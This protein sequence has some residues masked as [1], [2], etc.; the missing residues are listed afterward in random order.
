MRQ[1]KV[2]VIGCGGIAERAHIPNLLAEPQVRLE[3]LSDIDESKLVAIQ[4]KFNLPKDKSFTDYTKV[5]RL[6][7][8]DAVVIA[9][10]THTHGEIVLKAI[11]AE[12]HVFVE[13]PLSVTVA[14]AEAIV[15]SA[16]RAD[17]KVMVGYQHRFVSVHK[18]AKRY[19]RTGKIGVP[20]FGEVHSESLIVKPEEG[21]LLDYGV[22]LIDLLCWYLDDSKVKE[23]AALSYVDEEGA[24]EKHA[25]I[26][27]RFSNGVLGRIGAF[28]LESYTSWSASDRYIKLL[29][30]RGKLVVSQTGPTI[31]LYKEGSLMSRLRGPHTF[32]P[33]G[34]LQENLPL[35]E[36]AYRDEIH[37]FIQSILKDRKPKV[38]AEQGLMVQKILEAT[39][40]S[41][42]ERRFVKVNS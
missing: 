24:K 34:A 15:E 9:T 19:L 5:L 2:G 8:V 40:Q 39:Q 21:I 1:I 10:P 4:Q 3:A 36:A 12:K 22:H 33:R 6:E 23:V 38:D 13:K 41:I 32:M 31:T 25:V 35:T 28:F 42:K 18:I 16:R 29:G 37:D 26:I 17:V 27:M 30:T 7:D 20:F 11:E 14:E